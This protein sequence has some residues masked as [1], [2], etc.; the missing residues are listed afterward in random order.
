MTADQQIIVFYLGWWAFLALLATAGLHRYLVPVF[1][2]KGLRSRGVRRFGIIQVRAELSAQ[3]RKETLQHER[4][5]AKQ[6]CILPPFMFG[7][8]YMI[9]ACQRW[10]E[11]DAYA[12]S[13]R[14]GRPLLDC[15]KALAHSH[16]SGGMT[17]KN[18]SK[19]QT[20]ITRRI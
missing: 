18:I 15:A 7:L 20:A 12:A 10:L 16:Y 8:I 2:K 11:A 19:A 1:N 5:H 13:F 4:Q 6:S 17:Q 3:E 9:P 14:A